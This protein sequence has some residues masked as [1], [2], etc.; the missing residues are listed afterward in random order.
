MFEVNLIEIG[1]I[2]KRIFDKYLHTESIRLLPLTSLAFIKS[3]FASYNKKKCIWSCVT[4]PA[5]HEHRCI[6]FFQHITY[7]V[8]FKKSQPLIILKSKY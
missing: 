6:I 8:Y 1:I 5:V 4:N 3:V 2:Y 7:I